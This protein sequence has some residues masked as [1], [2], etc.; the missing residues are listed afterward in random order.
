[1]KYR[2]G[3][4]VAIPLAGIIRAGAVALL[5]TVCL[6]MS[7][8]MA[9]TITETVAFTATGFG[10]FPDLTGSF[11]IT[12]DST[13]HQFGTLDAFS[14]NLPS[15]Y[16]T[17]WSFVYDANG[18][19]QIGD[20]CGTTSCTITS[21]GNDTA[22]VIFS[23]VTALGGIMFSSAELTTNIPNG[24]SLGS[25]F[26]TQTGTAVVT[27]L[28]AALPLFATGLGA[29]GLLGWRRKRKA[30]SAAVG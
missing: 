14:S 3:L 17:A 29:L 22:D 11:T 30:T 12:F 21:P 24:I 16:G 2:T 15:G 27:P 25:A 28:P 4:A 13:Q 7:A 5:A 1:M 23:S 26:S 9:A 8:A 19:L 20:H 10:G 6:P 18:V